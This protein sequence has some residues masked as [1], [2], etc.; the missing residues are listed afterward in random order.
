MAAWLRI[1]AMLAVTA[2]L[3]SAMALSLNEGTPLRWAC[4]DVYLAR[5]EAAVSS[6]PFADPLAAAAVADNSQSTYTEQAVTVAAALSQIEGVQVSEPY[7]CYLG[8]QCEA[9]AEHD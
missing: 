5:A 1:C 8:N 3:G 2:Y 4:Y 9:C 6:D 7:Y